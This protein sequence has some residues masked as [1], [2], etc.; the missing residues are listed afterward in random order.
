[1]LNSNDL[2]ATFFCSRAKRWAGFSGLF[3][4]PKRG[5]ADLLIPRGLLAKLLRITGEGLLNLKDL[6]TVFPPSLERLVENEPLLR[7]LFF[8]Q[9]RAKLRRFTTKTCR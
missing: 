1:V 5:E 8:A 4:R 2:L 6:L 7:G 3:G 9:K